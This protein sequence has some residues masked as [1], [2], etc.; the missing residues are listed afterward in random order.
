MKHKTT[1]VNQKP[2][3]FHH[4]YPSASS[5]LVGRSILKCQSVD[6][7]SA[8]AGAVVKWLIRA[9]TPKEHVK[10]KADKLKI[11]NE[12]S[13]PVNSLRKTINSMGMARN[14]VVMAATLVV[15]FQKMAITKTAITGASIKAQQS[16]AYEKIEPNLPTI[17]DHTAP[18]TS[19]PI[20]DI[21]ANLTSCLSEA[22]FLINP[23]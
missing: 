23:L 17:G 7:I 4:G 5:S 18:K 13:K 15:R 3:L 20:P 16:C 8:S 22:F 19:R 6:S 2:I 14:N 11:L 1:R 9:I 10:I 21:C 12:A